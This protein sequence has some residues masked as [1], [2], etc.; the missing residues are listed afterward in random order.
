MLYT[1]KTT[2][3]KAM[4]FGFTGT[5]IVEE[6]KKI[7]NTTADV[8]GK[9]LHRYTIADGIRDKNVLGFDPY[10]I[11][12]YKDIDLRR[13][14]ALEQAKAKT[15]QEALSDPVKAE[16]YYKFMSPTQTP[17]AGYKNSEGKYVKGIEDLL[18]NTQYDTTEFREKVVEDILNNWTMFSRNNKFHALF[19]TTGICEAIYYYI[20]LKEQI[21]ISDQSNI[22]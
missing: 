12:I 15:E 11:L 2:F 21:I 9:E 4:F 22:Y 6:N 10:K 17:M 14:V 20:L 7:S 8:F 18:P 3:P 19:A 1:I 13:Q 5:P 16:I